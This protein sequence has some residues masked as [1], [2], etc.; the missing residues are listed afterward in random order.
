VHYYD[1]AI[2]LARFSAREPSE[3]EFRMGM[4]AAMAIQR[5]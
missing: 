5:L 4:D 1:S 2:Q 3:E